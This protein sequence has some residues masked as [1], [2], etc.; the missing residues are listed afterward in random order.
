METN[1][2]SYYFILE[3]NAANTPL[4]E[5]DNRKDSGGLMF[6]YQSEKV[7][8]NHVSQLCFYKSIKNP[9]M[10]TD[11]L[12]VD[13][14]NVFSKKVKDALEKHMPI[15]YLQ[16]VPAIIE[17]GKY[18]YTDFYIPNIFKSILTF[19][20]KLSEYEEIDEDFGSWMNTEK[21]VLNKEILSKI[22]LEDRLVY[23]AKED[24]QFRLYHQ[25]IIDIIK[26]VNPIGMIFVPVE[27]WNPGALF[28]FMRQ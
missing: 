23:T 4:L 11:C 12:T 6:L 15:K 1:N 19:D 25:S 18:K 3:H 10:N 13:C 28:D 8:E 7:P 26:S 27:E 9:N 17:H 21:I 22:P 20:E 5:N 14:F 24:S 16:L 2:F